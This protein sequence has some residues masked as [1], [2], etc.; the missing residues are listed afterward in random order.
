MRFSLKTGAVVASAALGRRRRGIV[1]C[2]RA[3]DRRRTGVQREAAHGGAAAELD[4]ERRQRFQ[5]ALLA[6]HAAESRQREGP[7]SAVAHEHGLGRAAEQFGPSADPAL[8]RHALRDQRRERR[9]RARRRHAA[10][11]SGRITAI[12]SRRPACRW[13]ARAAA[14]RSATARCSS[15][16]STRSSSRSTRRRARSS[17]RPSRAWQRASASRARRSITTGS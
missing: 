16:R 9:V 7:Q 17:G 8:R 5:P 11:S 12:P 6:A 4:H 1:D 14:S 13:A 3:Q 10:R 2:S 15:R